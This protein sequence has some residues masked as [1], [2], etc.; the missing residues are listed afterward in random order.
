MRAC[1]FV[2]ALVAAGCG[3]GKSVPPPPA[4]ADDAGYPSGPYGYVEGSVLP[5]LQFGGKDVP[6]GSYAGLHDSQGISLGGLRGAGVRYLVI[7]TV[8]AWCPDCQGDQ[9]LMMQLEHDDSDKGVVGMELM[10]EGA[11]DTSPTGNDLDAWSQDYD[12][13]GLIALDANRSFEHA[14]DTIAFPSYFLVDASTMTIVKRSSDTLLV[15]PL[16]P[17]LDVLLAE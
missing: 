3:G 7:E 5:D 11:Y 8:G 2:A 14:A 1:L 16:G 6:V 13:T 15:T 9:P 10:V 4:V 12:V 17:I